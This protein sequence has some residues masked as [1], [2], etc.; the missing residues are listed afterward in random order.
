[1]TDFRSDNVTGAHP[2][3][4][5]AVAEASAGPASAYG[6]DALTGRVVSR[7][8]Q[9]F[10]APEAAVF[11]VAT[12]TAANA[13]ALAT[14][15]PPYGAVYCYEESHIN[16][17]ECGAPEF[18]SGGAKLIG[19]PGDHGR[20]APATLAAALER[21]NHG[22]HHVKPA[23]LSLTQATCDGTVYPVAQ[24][25]EL[26]A[27]AHARGLKVHVDGARFANALVRLGCTP[28][29]A[30]WRAGIDALSFGA[31]KNGALG[32]EAVIL[33]DPELAEAF[34]YRRKRGGHLFSKMRF[35]A[36]Q[37]DAYLAGE[38]WLK[39][40]AHANAAAARLAE[41]LSAVPGVSLHHPVEANEIFVEV[42]EALAA[43]LEAAGFGFYRWPV[44]GRCI[45]R[46]VTAFDS[47]DDDVDRLV[48]SARASASA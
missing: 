21:P 1:M 11:L 40:A 29:E 18:F 14:M 9:V 16:V 46:L 27:T 4:L 24:I 38:L 8:R 10:E 26:A 39:N 36:A 19:L 47:R 22:V 3:I 37:M 45:L 48:A 34:A 5:Q 7:L 41:G 31:T 43:H 33:F 35:L 23:A 6:D 15:T 28:A 42:P 25:S 44:P 20:V 12:G 13:L 32:V 2:R 30:T 17:D